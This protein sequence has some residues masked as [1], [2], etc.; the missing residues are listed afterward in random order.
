MGRFQLCK[1]ERLCT[2]DTQFVA[3]KS[4]D[5]PRWQAILSGSFQNTIGSFW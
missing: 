5:N 3:T 1:F 2:A 4:T